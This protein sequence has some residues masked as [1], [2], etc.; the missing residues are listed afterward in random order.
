MPQT[1]RG[2]GWTVEL[3]G[4]VLIWEFLPEMELAAF[5]EE[6][7]PV[8]QNFL[9]EH[10]IDAMVT[11]V[12]LED[13]FDSEAFDVWEESARVADREGLQRWAVVAD[14]IKAISLRGKVDTGGLETFTTEDRSAAV[15]WARE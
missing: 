6:A 2:D 8:Y 9:A 10:D 4:G 15:E 5:R 3:D 7:F 11:D 1:K 12:R 14:G 13:P